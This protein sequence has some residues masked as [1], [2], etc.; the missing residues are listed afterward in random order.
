M[1]GGQ[2]WMLAMGHA[3]IFDP[4]LILLDEPSAGL[5]LDLVGEMFDNIDNLAESGTAVLMI[6]QNTKEALNRCDRGY[7][8]VNEEN[9]YTSTGERS[10]DDKQIRKEFLGG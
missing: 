10:L 3:V 1:S 5:A 2:R 9:R 7:I 4:A 8:L 6:E